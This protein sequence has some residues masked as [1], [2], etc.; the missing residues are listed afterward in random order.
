MNFV[1]QEIKY[2]S[3]KWFDEKVDD[4][5]PQEVETKGSGGRNK[6]KFKDDQDDS[7]STSTRKYY[8]IPGLDGIVESAC[9]TKQLDLVRFINERYGGHIDEIAYYIAKYALN[10][11]ALDIFQYIYQQTTPMQRM[12]K[13]VDTLAHRSNR[14]VVCKSFHTAVLL[15]VYQNGNQENII[16]SEITRADGYQTLDIVQFVDQQQLLREELVAYGVKNG[17]FEVAKYLFNRVPPNLIRDVFVHLGRVGSLDVLKYVVEQNVLALEEMQ[18]QLPA[19][20]RDLLLASPVN[21]DKIQYLK[22]TFSEDMVFGGNIYEWDLEALE[23]VTEI[24]PTVR[25]FSVRPYTVER[26][27]SNN[28]VEVVQWLD[29]HRHLTTNLYL[30]AN[31]SRSINMFRIVLKAQPVQRYNVNFLNIAASLGHLEMVQAIY[32]NH[33][34]TSGHELVKTR[35]FDKKDLLKQAVFPNC[36]GVFQYLA[37]IASE[38]TPDA[39]I[40]LSQELMECIK[41]DATST[42]QWILD[43]ASITPPGQQFNIVS[44]KIPMVDG[45]IFRVYSQDR[46]FQSKVSIEMYDV[47]ALHFESIDPDFN[48]KVLMSAISNGPLDLLKYIREKVGPKLYTAHIQRAVS[49]GNM[50]SLDYITSCFP[51]QKLPDWYLQSTMKQDFSSLLVF[52]PL[53][54]IKYL[55]ENY[56]NN[57]KDSFAMDEMPISNMAIV[58]NRQIQATFDYLLSKGVVQ[59]SLGLGLKFDLSKF[60]EGNCCWK[61]FD[62]FIHLYEY[63]EQQN[64]ST[65]NNNNLIMGKWP[66]DRTTNIDYIRFF[67]FNRS[68]GCSR[69][70][71]DKQLESQQPHT[72]LFLLKNRTEGYSQYLAD[73]YGKGDFYSKLL[74]QYSHLRFVPTTTAS[75]S[76]SPFSGYSFF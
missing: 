30:N 9:K 50:Q 7:S 18:R 46:Y 15:Y 76:A 74:S 56:F 35:L 34:P 13:V 31:S 32:N 51:D 36:L 10:Y 27:I 1:E 58:N 24:C 19:I 70:A 69:L 67:H 47:L 71:L 73:L 38:R 22:T 49:S 3:F 65:S 16:P 66:F 25:Q 12:V 60:I 11:Q 61:S 68:E 45:K 43:N 23:R 40:E 26:A 42:V 39:A 41:N 44:G 55:V 17:S 2:S 62:S 5:C 64:K 53:K 48:S 54:P 14:V 6:R 52:A 21:I 20:M 75:I 37:T 29:T 33:T 28:L 59:H 57:H 4:G 72:T 63:M 8:Y